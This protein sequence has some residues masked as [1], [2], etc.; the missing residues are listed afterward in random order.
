MTSSWVDATEEE[1][2]T[3]KMN[4]PPLRSSL[5]S[6]KS[7]SS[8]VVDSPGTDEPTDPDNLRLQKTGHWY[9]L[10][11]MARYRVVW[12]YLLVAL[13][14]S[15]TLAVPLQ[16]AFCDKASATLATPV[17]I[18]D[19]LFVVDLC[20]NFLFGYV[21]FNRATA[22]VEIISRP[23]LIAK[24][25]LRNWFALELL[26]LGPIATYTH[27][28]PIWV[29]WLELL[30][31]LRLQRLL[32]VQAR[33]RQRAN[34]SNSAPRRSMVAEKI[35]GIVKLLALFLV[36]SHICGCVYWFIGRIQEPSDSRPRWMALELEGDMCDLNSHHYVASVYWAMTTAL[37]IGY[38]DVVPNTT[39][40]R[41]FVCV[42]MLASSVL[43][44]SIFGQVTSLV[45]SLDDIQM[46]YRRHLQQYNE[47]TQMYKLPA[48][49]RLRIYSLIH[50]KWQLTRGFETESVISTLPSGLRR[51]V[52]LFLLSSSM[53]TFPLFVGTPANFVAAVVEMFRA[54]LVGACEFV[55]T[56]DEPGKHL[57]VI[58]TG[59]VEV[60]TVEGI[61]VGKLGRKQYFGEIA[62]LVDVR[63]TSSVRTLS[64][65]HFY[66]LAKTDFDEVL[67][68]YPELKERMVSKAMGR[69]KA[70]MR[71]RKAGA[72]PG[73]GE[74]TPADSP[75]GS[76]QPNRRL[77]GAAG[78][79][80]RAQQLASS[81]E[82]IYDP[83]IC[84]PLSSSG[85][86][87]VSS[88]SGRCSP[89]PSDGQRSPRPAG[90]TPRAAP[91]PPESGPGDNSP[92][93]QEAPWIE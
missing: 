11:P 64:R 38:G 8:F 91:G 23:D 79:E 71:V 61:S 30:K 84:D 37:T 70:I 66:K 59:L 5:D 25:Y 53:S 1:T 3:G 31:I 58:H 33:E 39:L 87:M 47:F 4:R 40:E 80:M 9:V 15:S 51:D 78:S 65:C 6:S 74:G 12:D 77:R 2:R 67:E 56:A 7:D 16:L 57:F 52:Q 48:S 50:Y 22:T 42:M 68:A 18:I 86:A 55:F 36:Y 73:S 44:A 75:A 14:L 29:H 88:D 35:A 72:S 54:D 32:R 81:G 90:D 63:R 60:I 45:H 83:Q 17:A 69:L 62:I 46:R 76:P 93:G 34:H 24:R 13:V 49:L 92:G 19:A 85:C 82:L 21:V 43:Y 89:V 28:N 20:S 26:S 27:G 10:H 41:I